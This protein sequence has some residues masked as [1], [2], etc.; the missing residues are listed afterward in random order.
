MNNDFI[1]FG[2]DQISLYFLCIFASLY[3]EGTS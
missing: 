1:I 3:S 2:V